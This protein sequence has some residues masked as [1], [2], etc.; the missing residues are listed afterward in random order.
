M[1]TEAGGLD[2]ARLLRYSRHILLDELGVEAQEKLLAAHVLVIGVGGLGNPRGT[3]SSEQP[4]S[5]I[6]TLVDGDQVEITNLQRQLLFL[7]G[8]RRQAKSNEAPPPN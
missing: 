4:A 6:M 1:S 3:L 5:A 7:D 8:R 2:D